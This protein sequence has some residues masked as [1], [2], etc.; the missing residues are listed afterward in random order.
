MPIKIFVDQA[1]NPE[2]HDTGLTDNIPHEHDLTYKVGVELAQL[3]RN[4]NR[5][6]VRLSRLSPTSII[7]TD[8][9]SSIKERVN[10]ANEWPADY[11]IGIHNNIDTEIG[12]SGTII[13]VK[14]TPN[15][16][17]RSIM[18][19]IIKQTGSKDGGIYKAEG[20]TLQNLNMPAAVISLGYLSALIDIVK[21]D[22][23]TKKFAQ[24][25]YEGLVNYIDK[26]K[27]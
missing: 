9:E 21:Y 10:M 5:F 22:T 6:E 4:D 16:L 18:D 14:D 17:A 24:G 12:K 27:S 19:S 26:Y 8:V 3:L 1:H 15:L 2:S 11:F 13:F 25:I 20:Y 7:G 23:D